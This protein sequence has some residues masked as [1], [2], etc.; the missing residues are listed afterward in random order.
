MLEKTALKTL[1][2]QCG[3]QLSKCGSRKEFLEIVDILKPYKTIHPLIRIGDDRDGGYL[4]PDDLSGIVACL[5][6]GVSD[7]T[8]F[9][10]DLLNYGI[11]SHLADASVEAPTDLPRTCSFTKRHVGCINDSRTMV[12]QSWIDELKLEQGDL[13]LQMDIEGAEYAT[14]LNV[15]DSVLDRFRI[16]VVELHFVD[17]FFD[18]YFRSVVF[19]CLKRLHARYAVVHIHPNNGCGVVHFRGLDVPRMLEITYLK[20]DRVITS[21]PATEFPHRLDRPCVAGPELHLPRYW[22]QN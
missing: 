11:P 17:R 5:S 8:N 20:R 6:P 19:P 12:V 16:I 7:R 18:P 13:M 2:G 15:P 21:V 1:V 14:L 22:F 3:Y 9:E 10:R 4:V